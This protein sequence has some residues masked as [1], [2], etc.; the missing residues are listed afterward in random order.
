MVLIYAL[1]IGIIVGSFLNV[2][3]HRL[4]RALIDYWDENKNHGSIGLKAPRISPFICLIAPK[5]T[6]PCCGKELR[7]FENIPVLSWLWLNGKCRHCSSPISVRYLLVEVMTGLCFLWSVWHFGE[8]WTSVLFCLFFAWCVSLF[9]IDLETFLLP[10][11][12]T[13]SL[14]WLGLLG[15]AFEMLPLAPTEAIF[16]ACFGYMILWSINGLYRL[17]RKQD[18]FGGGDYKLLAALGAWLGWSAIIPILGLASFFALLGISAVTLIK[19][20]EITL[21]KMLPF[22]PFLVISGA[23]ILVFQIEQ[24]LYVFIK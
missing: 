9:F 21:E 13:L 2:V 7:W 14:L 1:L 10:D 15:S 19:G 5:S 4:P 12:L 8:T 17:I 24:L 3:I 16:G 23:S 6:S 11:V 22:G 20:E 18:G